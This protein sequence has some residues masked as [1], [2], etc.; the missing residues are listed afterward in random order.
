LKRFYPWSNN[1]PE[2]VWRNK[3]ANKSYKEEK[4]VET[5]VIQHRKGDE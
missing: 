2:D 5:T 4:D 3:I 1:P